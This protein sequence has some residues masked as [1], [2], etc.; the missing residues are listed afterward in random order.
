MNTG[1]KRRGSVWRCFSPVLVYMLLQQCMSFVVLMV[2]YVKQGFLEMTD[3]SVEEFVN[4]IFSA[5]LENLELLSFI[6]MAASYFVLIPVFLWMRRKDKNQDK[7][8]GVYKETDQVPLVHYLILI[9]GGAASC[10][11]ASNMISMSGLVEASESYAE[12][13]N[14]LYSAGFAAELVVLGILSPIAEELLFRG[15]I[16]RRFKEFTAV[17]PAMLWASLTFALLHGNLVQGVYAFIIGF[18]LCYVYERYGSVKAPI[19]MH[20]ASNIVSVAASE[21]GI[22][23]FMYSSQS[24]FLISTFVCC[25]LVVAM[26]YLVEMYVRPI[27]EKSAPDPDGDANRNW[28]K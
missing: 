27:T 22:L 13:T 12:A 28:E 6:T 21:T 1:M 15:L 7:V 5:T 17:I 10:L 25:V 26:F 20:M 14:V 2:Y 8:L 24:M 18:I 16:Y 23:D 3:L 4:H 11:A 9:M 19:L